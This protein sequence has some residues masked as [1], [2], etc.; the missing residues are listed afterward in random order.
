MP[1][2]FK[3]PCKFTLSANEIN[4]YNQCH[5]K[6]YYASRDCLAIRSNTPRSSLDLGTVV[7]AA[8]AYYYTKLQE[9]I[10]K[11][12]IAIPTL[13]DCQDLMD[14]IPVYSIPLNNNGE[15]MLNDDNLD[16]YNT[17]IDIYREKIAYDLVDYEVIA[18][19]QSF[20]MDNWP[21][22]DVMYHG[23][24]DMV[25]RNRQNRKIYFFE[26]KT[27]KAYWPDIYARLNTQLH[28]YDAYGAFTYKE[29]FGGMIL[30]EIKK[31][32]SEKGYGQERRVYEYSEQERQLFFSWLARS[33]EQLISPDNS[34]EP[35][36]NYMECNGCEYASICLKFGYEVPMST[37]TIIED[38]SFVDKDG[39]PLF[40]YDPRKDEEE[41]E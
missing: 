32:K 39:K 26:H 12:G 17:I 5:R 4:Q 37:A 1:L 21:I 8:L 29:E 20:H 16:F 41:G 40:S 23:Y 19:E 24:I 25:V 11:N 22:N 14:T 30:N 38:K 15:C 6:R 18:C 27:V 3:A 9:L 13:E 31:A 35:C 7:H 36:N 33:T 2:N 10:D 28:I 34:H